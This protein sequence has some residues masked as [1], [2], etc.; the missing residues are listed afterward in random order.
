MIRKASDGWPD[1]LKV[2]YKANKY[3]LRNLDVETD[4]PLYNT[5]NWYTSKL[6]CYITVLPNR[7]R[8][9]TCGFVNWSNYIHQLVQT[10]CA[11][12]Q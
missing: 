6:L 11:I 12:V 10:N 2:K 1:D 4:Y 7:S 8:N 3:F 5:F 9:P